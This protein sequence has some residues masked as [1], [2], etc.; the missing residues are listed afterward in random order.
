MILSDLQALSSAPILFGDRHV[1]L[2]AN[3]L[4][5]T[6]DASGCS[7][8]LWDTLI[9]AGKNDNVPNVVHPKAVRAARGVL[10]ERLLDEAHAALRQDVVG[11]DEVLLWLIVQL[12]QDSGTLFVFYDDRDC[13]GSVGD[14][15]RAD[16]DEMTAVVLL[17]LHL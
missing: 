10:E 4:R 2:Q 14:R 17:E 7:P 1:A 12:K 15:K 13:A 6:V 16:N 8:Y 9:I 3:L 5:I 11:L